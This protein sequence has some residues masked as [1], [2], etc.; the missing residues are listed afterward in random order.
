MSRWSF[1]IF[2]DKSGHG[3]I[4]ESRGLAN[5]NE[6]EPKSLRDESDHL[7]EL[8]PRKPLITES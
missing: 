3:K 6:N 7:R 2:K 1:L 4:E 5:D 8:C